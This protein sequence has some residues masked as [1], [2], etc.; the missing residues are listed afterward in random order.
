MTPDSP[1]MPPWPHNR[2]PVPTTDVAMRKTYQL[3]LEGKNRDRLLESSKHDIRKYIRRE[4]RK[5]LP[6]GA[7]YW[8]F[9]MRFG[10][11][12]ASA[13][14]LPPAELIRSINALVADG[15]DQFFVEIL[16]KPGKRVPR[17]AGD[18]ALGDGGLDFEQD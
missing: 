7:D 5:D 9:D 6:E 12:E 15:G 8:D 3:N 18:H 13:V 10:V 11:D 16:R 1:V 4:R 17:A 2:R 14:A